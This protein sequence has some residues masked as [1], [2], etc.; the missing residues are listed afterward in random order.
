[1][2][3]RLYLALLF[4]P[5]T[6]NEHFLTLTGINEDDAREKIDQHYQ[7]K[8]LMGIWSEREYRVSY[9]TGLKK[10][11][12]FVRREN[13]KVKFHWLYSDSLKTARSTCYGRWPA[14]AILEIVDI[15]RFGLVYVQY[16]KPQQ[17][18]PL[19]A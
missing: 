18:R 17:N 4:D 16:F 12:C 3:K 13:G 2:E 5:K 9:P 6:T 15:S 11:A 8:Q 10:V 14:K 1:M 7:K 19:A